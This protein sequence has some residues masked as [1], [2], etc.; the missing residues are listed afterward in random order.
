MMD[1]ME[2]YSLTN[3]NTISGDDIPVRDML[4]QE[5]PKENRY[6]I[7]C[8]NKVL[9]LDRFC[10]N[11]GH[12]IG[13]IQEE[14]K[15]RATN[16]DSYENLPMN[17]WNFWQY[18]R[19]PIGFISTTW[20]IVDYLPTLDINLINIFVF[21]IDLSCAFFMIVTYYH[22]LMRNKIGYKFLNSWLVIELIVN[23]LTITINGFTDNYTNMED[24]V[25]YF[26]ITI[27]IFGIVWAL[28]NYKYFKKRKYLFDDS[29][30]NY[31]WETKK[32]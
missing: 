19:F 1:N 31:K 16:I 2:R 5:R 13:K 26:V 29:L 25:I 30:K 24:F 18:I 27:C 21:L 9:G 11:C 15:R 28:P 12:A 10:S 8:G 3:G 7:N 22:F 20:N 32:S 6:C 23:S 14:Q 17:W 4:V